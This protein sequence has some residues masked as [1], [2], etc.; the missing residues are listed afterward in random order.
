[1]KT[2]L[3]TVGFLILS[4][5]TYAIKITEE[6]YLGVP[7]FVIK[8]KKAVY[9]L[10]KAGGG[11]S[12]MFDKKGRNW[13]SFNKNGG[14]IPS[15]RSLP[16]FVNDQNGLDKGV[17]QPGQNKC[18]SFI[19]DKHTILT[20]SKNGN[21]QWRWKFYDKYARVTIEKIAP[22][23]KYW[24]VYS[25]TIAGKNDP[26]N[27]YWGNNLGGPRYDIPEL[28]NGKEILGNWMWAY[29]GDK[30]EKGVMYVGMVK[31]DRFLDSFAYVENTKANEPLDGMALFSFGRHSNQPQLVSRNNSFIF[32]II[33]ERVKNTSRHESVKKELRNIFKSLP[34]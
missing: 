9:Y 21:W 28:L 27:Q 10:D 12:G 15:S 31:P 1:M 32:G 30:D 6:N 3:S 13:M 14:V 20:I 24:F 2:F 34:Q 26:D 11:L 22:E 29:F 25:G 19:V 33:W 8:T 5:S 4:I 17:G 18:Y 16:G 7:H 23:S